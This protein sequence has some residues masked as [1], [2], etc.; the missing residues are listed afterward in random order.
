LGNRGKLGG[1]SV[2]IRARKMAMTTSQLAA[3]GICRWKVS[4]A[5]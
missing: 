3:S 1:S 4:W 5:E 2:P